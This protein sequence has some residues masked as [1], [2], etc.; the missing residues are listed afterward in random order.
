MHKEDDDKDRLIRKLERESEQKTKWL[1]LIAH[2]LRGTLG[3]V[4]WLLTAYKEKSLTPEVIE[5]FL[6]EIHREIEMNEKMLEDTF[7]WVNQQLQ[8]F[9]TKHKKVVIKES[10][11]EIESRLEDIVAAKKIQ[12]NSF[13]KEEVYLLTDPILFSFILKK[14]LENAVKYSYEYG[15]I[16]VDVKEE[17]GNIEICIQD[18]GVGM[19]SPTLE[20]IFSMDKSPFTGP[21]GEKGRGLSMVIVQDF[22]R[23]LQGSIQVTSDLEKGTQVLLRFPI[24]EKR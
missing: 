16:N 3:N 9:R 24:R 5:G 17:K 21:E 8:G 22:V 19:S 2:D 12:I 13:V 18:Y 20:R 15:E 1:S 6:P 7:S 11:R 14:C 4:R 10:L 23:D